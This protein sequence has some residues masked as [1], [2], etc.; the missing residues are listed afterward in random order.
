[1]VLG[2]HDEVNHSCALLQSRDSIPW[3]DRPSCTNRISG[4][5]S[6]KVGYG[7]SV[8]MQKLGTAHVLAVGGHEGCLD[9]GI[10]SYRRALLVLVNESRF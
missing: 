9:V 10:R 2:G 1:M 6:R 3:F 8:C 5:M 7:F 4:L